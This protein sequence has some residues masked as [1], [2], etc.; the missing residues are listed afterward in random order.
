MCLPIVACWFSK[1]NSN[2]LPSIAHQ[3]DLLICMA[4]SHTPDIRL[5]GLITILVSGN[6]VTN[7]DPPMLIDFSVHHR[8]FQGAGTCMAEGLGLEIWRS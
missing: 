4:E 6:W 1:T 3:D 2:Y 5:F 8:G 7:T